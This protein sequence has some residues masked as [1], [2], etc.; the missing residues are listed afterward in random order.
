MNDIQGSFFDKSK[1]VF[2]CILIFLF[3]QKLFRGFHTNTYFIFYIVTHT[4]LKD[5][6]K[7]S[8]S[9]RKSFVHTPK[10]CHMKNNCQSY[11]FIEK[12]LKVLVNLVYR[13]FLNKIYLFPLFVR[14]KS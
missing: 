8:F 5:V 7:T 14:L 3:L 1:Y 4:N 12:H 13:V 2:Y 11:G 10:K 6:L 9:R